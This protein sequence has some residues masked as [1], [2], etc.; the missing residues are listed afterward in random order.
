MA[1]DFLPRFGEALKTHFEAPLGSI[2][3]IN[4]LNSAWDLWK[5]ELSEGTSG[6][7]FRWLTDGL[8]EL[9]RR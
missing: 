5:Q 1:S 4:R 7:A 9:K 2:Q 8:K 6:D 3:E